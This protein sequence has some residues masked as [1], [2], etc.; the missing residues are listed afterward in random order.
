MILDQPAFSLLITPPYDI[1]PYCNNCKQRGKLTYRCLPPS[2]H[3]SAG[4]HSRRKTRERSV[5]MP[6]VEKQ[7]S[8]VQE[9][10]SNV[11]PGGLSFEVVLE[12]PKTD[13][14]P[15]IKCPPTPT[16]SAEDIEKK[17]KVF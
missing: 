16:L 13:E 17:L 3:Q 5:A 15:N 8:T 1:D 7:A 10:E 2:I 9:G 11:K 4:Y 12:G 6:E 14:K